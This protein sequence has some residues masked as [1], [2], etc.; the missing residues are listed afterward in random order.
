MGFVRLCCS[1]QHG[2]EACSV[3]LHETTPRMIQK[4]AFTR[5]IQFLLVLTLC[6]RVG[7]AQS[8]DPL[9]LESISDPG[10][11]TVATLTEANG[12]RNGP[13]YAGAT[14]YYPTNGT[15]PYPSI[16]IVPGYISA[17]SSIQ[18]WGPFLASHGIVTMTIGTNS[19]L[20][21]PPARRNALLDAIITITE[22]NTRTGS[23]LN[24]QIDTERFA[25]SGWSMGGGG[26]QL[27]A[28]ADPSLKAVVALC[29]WLD[30]QTPASAIAHPVPLLILS[31]EQ[32]G[33]APPASHANVHYNNTPATT[34]KLLFEIDNAGH[35]VANTPSGGQGYAGKIA[36]SWLKYYLVG[37]SCYCPLLL[38]A[39]S[40][41][42]RYETNVECNSITTSLND[43]D[44][45]S[46]PVIHLYPN[47]SSGPIQLEV[48]ITGDGAMYEIMSLAGARIYGG[49]LSRQ[50][51]TIDIEDLSSGVYLRQVVTPQRSV[52]IKFIVN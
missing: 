14:I 36:L 32:D 31:A 2:S 5:R 29:P 9:T 34:N 49:S 25:V 7:F 47:P 24:G 8:C 39:P 1:T 45:E 11:F 38:D 16:V 35:N 30:T 46:E 17:Q 13:A 23:P 4:Y 43:L 27:A 41:A 48:D 50:S 15:P 19:P 18:A 37:D 3:S 6:A 42:S 26:A 21:T 33:T 10:M 20:D 40:T 28:A 51:T 52:R 44:S 12:I 22:E